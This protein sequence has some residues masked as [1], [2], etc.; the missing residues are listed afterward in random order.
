MRKNNNNNKR[1]F[2]LLAAVDH[3]QSQQKI[4]YSCSSPCGKLRS[5]LIKANVLNYAQK[6]NRDLAVTVFEPCLKLSRK[7]SK[8]APEFPENVRSFLK[9]ILRRSAKTFVKHVSA[10]A[11]VSRWC[12][13]RA[14]SIRTVS[15]HELQGC[16]RHQRILCT[17][18]K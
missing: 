9:R 16:W 3:Q 18:N 5:N 12:G 17:D 4:T 6:H 2:T 14:N 8:C 1:I 10:R 11:A 13:Q 7:Q 15:F